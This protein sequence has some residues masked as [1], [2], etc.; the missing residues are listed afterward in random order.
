M[1]TK[2]SII[3]TGLIVA[4]LGIILGSTFVSWSYTAGSPDAC[5]GSPADK[6]TCAQPSCHEGSAVY[7]AG[8]ITSNIPEAGYVPGTTYTITGTVFGS[9]SAKR[10]GFQISPQNQTGQLLGTMIV[11]NSKETKLTKKG[12]YITQKDLGVEGRAYKS[13]SF[14][15]KAPAAGTGK[16]TFYGCFLV[17][18]KTEGIFTSR[19]E[20]PEGK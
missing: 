9:T 14:N 1:R 20:V 13:W 12:K 19:L 7:K 6:A 10:F 8:L 4:T 18:G 15:W 3:L 16:V 2:R 5:T 17:G 11:T